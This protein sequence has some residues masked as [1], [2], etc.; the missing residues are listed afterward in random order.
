MDEEE[1]N[2]RDGLGERNVLGAERG[3]GMRNWGLSL[4][5]EYLIK[6]C[7]RNRKRGGSARGGVG[8]NRKGAKRTKEEEEGRKIEKL[9]NLKVTLVDPCVLRERKA[10]RTV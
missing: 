4:V 1:S 2:R 7:N 3:R 8:I 9:I 5:F 6:K 10:S